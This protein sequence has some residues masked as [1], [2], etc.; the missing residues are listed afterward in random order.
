MNF[1][2][3]KGSLYAEYTKEYI[4]HFILSNNLLDEDALKN[5]TNREKRDGSNYHIT[6]VNMVEMK[7]IDKT[8]L[9]NI[10]NYSD[11]VVKMIG[12]GK[13]NT[14]ESSVIYIVCMSDKLQLLRRELGLDPCDLHITL[15]FTNGDIYGANKSLDT[16]RNVNTALLTKILDSVNLDSS[17]DCDIINWIL[18]NNY[19]NSEMT[20]KL[21]KILKGNIK[22]IKN[23]SL[24]F[25]ILSFLENQEYVDA[26]Y[27]KNKKLLAHTYKKNIVEIFTNRIKNGCFKF[28]N[29]NFIN[30][31][32]QILNH[33]VDNNIEWIRETDPKIKFNYYWADITSESVVFNSHA[34]PRNFTFVSGNLA[35]SSIP[36]RKEYFTVFKHMGI[37]N[38]ITLMETPLNNELYKDTPINVYHFLVDDQAPPSDS[39]ALEAIE[40]IKSGK[41]VVH[42]MGG[43]GRTATLLIAYLMYEE[44]MSMS[45]ARHKLDARKT[46][47]SDSQKLFLS[48]FYKGC[49]TVYKDNK[50]RKSKIKLPSLILTVGLPA[51]GKSTFSKILECQ[52][53]GVV[54]VNQDEIRTKGKCDE[55]VSSETK[56]GKTVILD[57]CNIEKNDRKYWTSLNM[58]RSDIWCLYFS[59]SEE[60]CKWRI[61]NRKD[62]PTVKPWAGSNI[63]EQMAKKL[64]EPS[65]DEGYDRLIIIPSFKEANQLLLQ[66]GCDITGV[67]EDNHD[68]IIKFPRTKHM[69]NL[70]AATRDDLILDKDHIKELLNTQVYIEEKIDGANMGISIKDYT[71]VVQNRSHYV[72][73]DYHQQFKPLSNWIK[74]HTADLWHILE[75]ESK[76]LYGE[77][78]CAKHSIHYTS[79]PDYFIAFDLYDKNEKRFYSRERFEKILEGT[80]ICIVPLITKGVF[81]NVKQ[82]LDLV[83]TQSSYYNGQIEGLYIRRCNSKWLEYRTK[84]VR[85]DFIGGNEHWTKGIITLN[86]IMHKS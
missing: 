58:G 17:S 72:T 28:H 69:H 83:K 55:L 11:S 14:S 8:K 29:P 9:E 68:N 64:E 5:M 71:I 42:C 19:I 31:T 34:L 20:Y 59:A 67:S 1:T 80:S 37:E 82:I 53:S 18:K 48:D 51:S 46:I 43:V 32:L 57:R 6:V 10:Y 74:N 27:I 75:D 2:F 84:I 22:K 41:T 26:I 50:K 4:H 15:D 61:K 13:I 79:L 52:I 66:I 86:T 76:I 7:T 38:V 33:P 63:V 24:K 81:S 54:R 62:H 45:D 30:K 23:P 12:I 16:I 35:G 65:I 39:Q 44:N 25:N 21:E 47:L 70:G 36:S 77:W 78:V 60:E 49:Q 56:K 73:S 40:I 3:T 85:N